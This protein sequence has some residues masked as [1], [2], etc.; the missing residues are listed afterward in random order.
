LE[1][2][3]WLA[4]LARRKERSKR[5]KKD[6]GKKRGGGKFRCREESLFR[7]K[8]KVALDG[9]GEKKA[10]EWESGAP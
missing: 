4:H 7:Q 6:A 2:C 9:R 3:S 5:K 8:K 1:L 10:T